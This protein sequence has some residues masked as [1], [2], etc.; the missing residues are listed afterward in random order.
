[1][2]FFLPSLTSLL[3]LVMPRPCS[4]T[5]KVMSLPSHGRSSDFP[6]PRYATSS[7]YSPTFLC[8]NL[9]LVFLVSL[10]FPSLYSLLLGPLVAVCLI[11]LTLNICLI[12]SFIHSPIICSSS[13]PFSSSFHSSLF[14]LSDFPFQRSFSVPPLSQHSFCCTL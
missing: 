8:K 14:T 3:S 12:A 9:S 4:I 11:H 1:M 10:S 6:P 7:Y 5:Q 13:N 2:S